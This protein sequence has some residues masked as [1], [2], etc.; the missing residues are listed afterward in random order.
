[1]ISLPRVSFGTAAIAGIVEGVDEEQA[2]AVLECAWASGLRYFDTAPHYGQG[3]AERRIGDFLRSRHS[4]DWILS[5]KVGRLLK[6][7][8]SVR[9]PLNKF[10]E[11]LPFSQHYDYSYNGIMRSVED[12]F[13]RLGLCRIDILYAHDL[14]TYTHG[15]NADR[16]LRQFFDSGVRALQE[17]KSQSVIKAFGLGVN[18]AQVCLDVL[19]EC[20]LD[21]LLLAGRYTLLDRTAERTLLPLCKA[22]NTGLVIGGVLN[23][24]I[25]ATGARPGALFNFQPASD[26]MLEHV[27]QLET[28]CEQYGIRLPAAAMQFPLRNEQVLSVLTGPGRVEYLEENLA[29]MNQAIPEAFWKA[30]DALQ[31]TS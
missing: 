3:L 7:D 31:I 19:H 15:D 24:G 6:A 23:S 17:L 16:Y 5:T 28:L 20:D 12:S 13:Q 4:D 22:R 1:M 21:L 10:V 18:D 14:G 11:P 25:L 8:R 29:L 27:R 30:A 9:G 2:N 26:L